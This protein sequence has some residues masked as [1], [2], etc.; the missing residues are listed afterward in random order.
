MRVEAP[1]VRVIWCDFG[2]CSVSLL[3]TSEL[4]AFRLPGVGS[5]AFA[6]AAMT[7]KTNERSYAMVLVGVERLPRSRA[8]FSDRFRVAVG[9]YA[10]KFR[11][12]IHYH[13]VREFWGLDMERFAAAQTIAALDSHSLPAWLKTNAWASVTGLL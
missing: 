11:L 5:L 12:R 9:N 1:L 13:E 6:C 4:G 3:T 10:S 7:P 8:M 2:R